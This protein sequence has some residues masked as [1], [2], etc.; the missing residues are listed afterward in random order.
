M[1][2]FRYRWRLTFSHGLCIR[3]VRGGEAIKAL[4][5][6]LDRLDG[7]P[8][9]HSVG[10]AIL[11]KLMELLNILDDVVFSASALLYREEKGLIKFSGNVEATAQRLIARLKRDNLGYARDARKLESMLARLKEKKTP[12]P[13]KFKVK[14]EEDKA[15][16]ASEEA[17]KK[18]VVLLL[19]DITGFIEDMDH[20]IEDIHLG[21]KAQKRGVLNS[22]MLRENIIIRSNFRLGRKTKAQGIESW[23]LLKGIN[24]KLSYFGRIVKRGKKL[25][26]S[27]VKDLLRYCRMESNDLSNVFTFVFQ[28]INRAK[29]MLITVGE[30]IEKN[31]LLRG[32]N[33]D[34]GAV[35]ERLIKL[36]EEI[37]VQ[38]K[39]L[40][41]EFKRRGFMVT[42]QMEQEI[43][44]AA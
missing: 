40:H 15:R 21:A 32:L 20:K 28:L 7:M 14:V 11:S 25:D 6:N 31:P 29:G 3:L 10:K 13:I 16:I 43:K 24:K 4:S 34:Y 37:E 30:K 12:E 44:A 33:G 27:D 5:E 35:K 26:E 36:R 38:Q 42:R 17:R 39:R 18:E 2:W 19:H 22:Y 8:I 9:S 41:N 23:Q 1:L